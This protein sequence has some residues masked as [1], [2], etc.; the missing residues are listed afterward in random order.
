MFLDDNPHRR[1]NILTG[2]WIKVSPHRTKRPW[3]GQVENANVIQRLKHDKNCYLCPGNSR[4]GGK[5]TPRYTDTYSFNNDFAALLFNTESESI[6]TAFFKAESEKGICK[7][8]CFS[9]R[10]DLTIPVME[11][12]E[13]EKVIR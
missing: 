7:V 4:A 11:R 8:L 5:M 1:Y 12:E 2:E 3:Q 9:P 10:H 13:I 6:N